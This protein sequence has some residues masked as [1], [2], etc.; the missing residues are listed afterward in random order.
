MKSIVG[1]LIHALAVVTICIAAPARAAVPVVW[2]SSW[3]GSSKNLQAIVNALYGT[4][5]IDVKTDYL[6]ARPGD[7]DPWFWVDEQFSALMVKEVAGNAD[8]N[9]VGWF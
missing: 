8:Y 9:Q 1:R 5:R 6:G 4:G 7:P 3:D 2:G